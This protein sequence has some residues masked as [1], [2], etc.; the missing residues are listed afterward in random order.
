MNK[1]SGEYEQNTKWY[2]VKTRIEGIEKGLL[3]DGINSKE[4]D[5]VISVGRTGEPSVEGV[6][7][8]VIELSEMVGLEIGGFEYSPKRATAIRNVYFGRYQSSLSMIDYILPD[9]YTEM[10]I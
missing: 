7:S 10:V 1:E 2:Q 9:H 8:F 5:V 4:N 3:K 6:E